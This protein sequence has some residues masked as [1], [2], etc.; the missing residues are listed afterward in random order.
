MLFPFPPTHPTRIRNPNSWF[1]CLI[2]Y[3]LLLFN[4]SCTGYETVNIWTS[5]TPEQ[6]ALRSLFGNPC[7]NAANDSFFLFGGLDPK[8]LSRG[9][10][11]SYNFTST[12]WS[13]VQAQ[14]TSGIV[15][16]LS[17]F[18]S[19]SPPYSLSLSLSL[20]PL[21]SLSIWTCSVC[22]CVCVVVVVVDIWGHTEYREN[23]VSMTEKNDSR[24]PRSFMQ[25]T[26]TVEG[27]IRARADSTLHNP[28]FML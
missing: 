19:L 1:V 3:E 13:L 12:E 18:I 26:I 2:Y 15:F 7:L 25:R 4:F 20:Y 10:L 24:V 9:D 6:P 5:L 17:L 23:A 16:S 28:I 8:G 11:W 21:P 22:V 14:C 27:F